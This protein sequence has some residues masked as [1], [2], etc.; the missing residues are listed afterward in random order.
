MLAPSRSFGLDEESKQRLGAAEACA[1]DR[2]AFHAGPLR[3]GEEEH[4]QS[5]ERWLVADD[6]HSGDR[7]RHVA[8]AVEELGEARRI[9]DPLV[10]F[11]VLDAEGRC[12]DLG[13]LNGA[14]ERAR[15]DEV[16][17]LLSFEEELRSA[18]HPS[19]S[20]GSE[21]P[22]LVWIS[23]LGVFVTDQVHVELTHGSGS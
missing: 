18:S 17:G 14:N 3:V 21:R 19:S 20:F 2:S 16:D 12:E 8:D 7:G 1:Q 15:A 9:G 23:I 6:G 22:V 10:D 4:D 11:D 5:A 13:G